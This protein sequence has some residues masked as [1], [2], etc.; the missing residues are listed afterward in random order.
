MGGMLVQRA[1]CISKS[2][3]FHLKDAIQGTHFKNAA[4]N[5]DQP[6]SWPELTLHA[7]GW[8]LYRH[9]FTRQTRTHKSA[10]SNQIPLSTPQKCK[11]KR[12]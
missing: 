11:V 2:T 8:L 3:T 6:R 10:V 7:A 4:R 5:A 9:T 1:K 12:P